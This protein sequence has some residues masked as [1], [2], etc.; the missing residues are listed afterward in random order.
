MS[1]TPAPQAF[2]KQGWSFESAADCVRRSDWE[3]ALEAYGAL[4][5][6]H[7]AHAEVRCNLGLIEQL[8]DHGPA[9]LRHFDEAVRLQPEAVRPYLLRADLHKAC[10]RHEAALRDYDTALMRQ[11]GLE[12]SLQA[13]QK[14]E[15]EPPRPSSSPSADRDAQAHLHANRGTTLHALGRHAD[16]LESFD[17]ALEC[18]AQTPGLH[19]NRGNALRELGR[20]EEAIASF[21]AALVHDGSDHQA[22]F[23]RGL[24]LGALGRWEAALDEA[25]AVI[26]AC[27]AHAR[28]YTARGD[29]LKNLGRKVEALQA[30]DRALDLDDQAAHTHLNRGNTL[31]EMGRAEE[32]LQAYAQATTLDPSDWEAHYNRG[33]ALH[34]LRLIPQALQSYGLARR[35]APDEHRIEWNESLALLMS[36]HW[37]EGWLAYESRWRLEAPDPALI[38]QGGQRWTGRQSLQA[39]RMLLVAEQGLGDSLQFCRYVPLVMGLGADVTLLVPEP[40]RPLLESIAPGLRVVTRLA[41]QDRFDF[42][43]PLMSLPLTLQRF[44]PRQGGHHPYL[45]ADRQLVQQR[46]DAHPR[47]ARL[48]VGLAWSGNRANPSDAHRSMALASLLQAVPT[49]ID[50]VV[51]QGDIRQDDEVALAK[52][53]GLTHDRQGLE[54]FAGTAAWCELV[55]LVLTV[56]TSIAHLAGALGRPTWLML[57]QMA[58]WRW[59]MDRD[60]TP[61][62]PRTRLFRQSRSGCWDDVL[63][64]VHSALLAFRDSP[65]RPPMR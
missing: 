30:Y 19:Y 51:L 21:D 16:A 7:P 55:D 39:Q 4:A 40:L 48:R 61:W 53:A 25:D 64:R 12:A 49:G 56:D 3:G 58:D 23:N 50:L 22:H 5:L 44:D 32:A 28:A 63:D 42:H 27:P 41:P 46:A 2:A 45:Q 14:P 15:P 54:G 17:A 18:A 31:R 37:H 57:H 36:Q 9:A 20:H 11:S 59:L 26:A 29:W 60:D 52:A 6:E 33:I 35:L 43:C 8:L 38:Q 24:C 65:T 13:K 34:D 10:G 47:S 62:Y 1:I